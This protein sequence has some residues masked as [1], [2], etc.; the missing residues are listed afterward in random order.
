[1]EEEHG[2]GL[3]RETATPGGNL[4]GMNSGRLARE[5]LI[6]AQHTMTII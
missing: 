5:G 4:A 6:S 1:M 3:K 2:K